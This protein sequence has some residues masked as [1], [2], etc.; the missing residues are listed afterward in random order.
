MKN[1]DQTFPVATVT[2]LVS[3]VLIVIGYLN[4]DLAIKAAFEALGWAGGGSGV[5]GIAR[6]MVGKGK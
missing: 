1:L 6:S 3:I 2:F 5:V 4:G